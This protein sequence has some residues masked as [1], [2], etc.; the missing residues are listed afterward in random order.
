VPGPY[1]TRR[2]FVQKDTVFH[3]QAEKWKDSDPEGAAL[4][5]AVSRFGTGDWLTDGSRNDVESRVD[6]MLDEA[7][8]AVR[9]LVSYRIPN[10]DGGSFSAGGAESRQEYVS[11]CKA[12]ARALKGRNALLWVEPDAISMSEKLTSEERGERLALLK[13]TSAILAEAGYW[14]YL[15]CGSSNWIR[16]T[17]IA[18]LLVRA[19]VEQCK[20]FGLNCS[21]T[22][23][24]LDEMRYGVEIRRI[25]GAHHGYLV[26]CGRNGRGPRRKCAEDTS[27][28]HWCNVPGRAIGMRPTLNLPAQYV[29]AGLHGICWTKNPGGS[30]GECNRGEPKAGAWWPERAREQARDA[31]PPLVWPRL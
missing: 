19:G 14:V 7:G 23:W 16:P 28:D 4:M 13:E 15:D 5:R 22:Q 9:L 20:G 1:A 11:W 21:G 26:D 27:I 2:L 17:R 30:D 10:R 25:L 6:R 29:A 18:E 8:S 12:L 24:L 3:R 31:W